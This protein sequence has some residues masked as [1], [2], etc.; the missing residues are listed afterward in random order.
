MKKRLLL[1]TLVICSLFSAH[2]QNF[3]L[4]GMTEGGG[5]KFLGNIF[6]YNPG[7]TSDSDVYDFAGWYGAN[8]YGSLYQASDGLLYG[9]AYE[10]GPGSQNFG[11]A[12]SIDPVAGVLNAIYNFDSLHGS[13]PTGS[14]MQA[15]DGQLYGMTY[16]GG[17]KNYGVIF[18]YNISTQKDSVVFYFDSIHGRWPNGTLLQAKDSLL[19]GMTNGGG[20]LDDGVV[21]SFNI[22]TGQEKVLVNLTGTNGAWP[23]GDMVQAPNGLLYGMTNIGGTANKGVLFSYNPVTGKD[24]VKVNFSGANGQWPFGN[25]TV[26]WNGL[27]YGTTQAGGAHGLGAIF[28]YNTSTSKYTLLSS[29][30]SVKQAAYLPIGTMVQ[31][32]NGLLYG[33]TN[34]GGPG[35]N[36]AIFQFN[37]ITNQDSIDTYFNGTNGQLPQYGS[38][39]VRGGPTGINSVTNMQQSACVYPNPFNSVATIRFSKPG[40][41][42]M[43]ILDVTGKVLFS[44]E[45]GGAQYEFSRGSLATGIYF[46]RVLDDKKQLASINKV[47]VQ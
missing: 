31:A 21:F 45:C 34:S 33:M 22:K 2:A 35:N 46:V 17:H 43:D 26:A 20:P 32:P 19:Y 18:S 47:V 1:L 40:K 6:K 29:F 13:Y 39:I 8:P 42:Y 10:G 14:F 11:V 23:I 7:A 41:H 9:M 16:Y 3:S 12:F 44:M 37:T 5:S 15:S 27:L 36:G 4:W 30:D 24:S 25:V 28:S 38:L